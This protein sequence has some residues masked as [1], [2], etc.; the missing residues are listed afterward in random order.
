MKPM[1]MAKPDM[2]VTEFDSNCCLTFDPDKGRGAV[3]DVDRLS[4]LCSTHIEARVF[5]SSGAEGVGALCLSDAVW[6][7]LQRVPGLAIPAWCLWKPISVWSNSVPEE[8]PAYYI[9]LYNTEQFYRFSF[10]KLVLLL[11]VYGGHGIYSKCD[12]HLGICQKYM[13]KQKLHQERTLSS[14]ITVHMSVYWL[15]ISDDCSV[16]HTLP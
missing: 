6:E 9:T 12:I 2:R 14:K 5:R 7:E 8:P 3:S 13:R 16:S 10:H 11:L 1:Q 4:S 15:Q